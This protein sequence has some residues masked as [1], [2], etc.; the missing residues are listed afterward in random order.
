[1][2]NIYYE[3]N[4]AGGISEVNYQLA[5]NKYI[6]SGIGKSI[7]FQFNVPKPVDETK[8]KS[9]SLIPGLNLFSRKGGKRGTRRYKKRAGT[10][11]QK[12]RRGTHRKR[13][14]TTK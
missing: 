10:H 13:K 9:S 2:D 11:R 14:N 8:P 7:M 5:L 4:I 12:K 6:T 1:M 3:L